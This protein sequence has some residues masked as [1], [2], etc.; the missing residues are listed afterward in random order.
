M[1]NKTLRKCYK[2]HLTPKDWSD[3]SVTCH[4]EQSY[5][6]IIQ[7]QAEADHLVQMTADAPKDKVSGNFM[8]GAVHLGFHK[9]N[10][11]GW[12]TVKGI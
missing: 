11:E 1:F 5:L 10:T 2:F 7:S 6:A 4:A 8:S 12:K 3:A 9:S